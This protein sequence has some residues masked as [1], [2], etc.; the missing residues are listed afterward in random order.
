MCVCFFFHSFLVTGVEYRP[1]RIDNENS[2]SNLSM[3]ASSI[4]ST[5]NQFDKTGLSSTNE[6]SLEDILPASTNVSD[7]KLHIP[8]FQFQLGSSLFFCMCVPS[9]FECISFHGAKSCSVKI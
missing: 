4:Q 5:L 9:L 7:I 2:K 3:N 8:A 6:T 1:L